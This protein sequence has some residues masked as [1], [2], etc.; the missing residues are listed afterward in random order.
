M[1]VCDDPSDSVRD[2]LTMTAG[3]A[4][5]PIPRIISVDDHVVEPAHVWTTRVPARFRDALVAIDVAG[6]SYGEA[7]K[8]LRVREGTIA[9][10]LFR[11]RSQVAKSLSR[12]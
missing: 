10:R 12:P 8:A 7:G 1:T 3:A 11:A 9:S 6:L 5:T 4:T 2:S